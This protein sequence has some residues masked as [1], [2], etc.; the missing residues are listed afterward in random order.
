VTPGPLVAPPVGRRPVIRVVAPSGTLLGHEAALDGGLT[1]LE[2]AGCEVRFDPARRAEVARGYLAGGDERR[3]DEVLAALAE[4]GV[5]IVWFARGGSGLGRIV[6]WVLRGAARLAPRH[7][8]GFS[9]AT[10]LLNTLA[11][12]LGWLTW[13]GPVVTSLGRPDLLTVD[14]DVALARLGG[15]RPRPPAEAGPPTV[16]GRLFGGNLTVLASLA[17]TPSLPR[18]R[19][20]LWLLEDVAEAPYR[21]DRTLA[22]LRAAG[23]FTGARGV[24]LGDLGLTAEDAAAVEATFVADL[25]PLPVLGGAPAGHRGRLDLL[26]IG[27]QVAAYPNG[28]VDLGRVPR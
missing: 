21:L 15:E 1:R 11:A 24:W 23:L 28:T 27:G 19:G 25:S 5:E 26:P 8:V 3:A 13:H 17:G 6:E 9:D 7:V 18:V 4:P 22:Q 10:T 14:L 20:A 12:R 2:G 16:S